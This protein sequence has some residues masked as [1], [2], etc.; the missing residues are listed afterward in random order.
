MADLTESE[1]LIKLAIDKF[2]YQYSKNLVPSAF[3]ISSIIPNR[4]YQLAYQIESI[5][6]VDLLKLRIYVNMEDSDA[7]GNYTLS[8]SGEPV[9]G[10][11]GDETYI[12][13]GTIDK[14][15]Y[16]TFTYKFQFIGLDNLYTLNAIID[17]LGNAID[18]GNGFYLGY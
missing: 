10:G 13:Y 6:S 8:L 5:D 16:E 9:S 14:Y 3:S 11:L 17:D 18:A 2:N 1:F 15:Y 7:L 12:A 4:A